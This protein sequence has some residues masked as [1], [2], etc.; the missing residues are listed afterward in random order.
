M[1]RKPKRKSSRQCTRNYKCRKMEKWSSKG[2]CSRG[3]A[4]TFKHDR[5]KQEKGQEEGPVLL[6]KRE[7]TRNEI[8]MWKKSPKVPVRDE[9]QINQS[10]LISRRGNVKRN[11]HAIFGTHLTL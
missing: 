11:P 3:D 5:N 10:A 9:S 2:Q 6:P 7:D 1:K 4:C 8:S